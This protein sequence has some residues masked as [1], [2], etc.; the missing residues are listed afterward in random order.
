MA[1]CRVSKIDKEATDRLLMRESYKYRRR[2]NYREI[3]N[4]FQILGPR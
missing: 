3:G 4:E 2:A 1:K